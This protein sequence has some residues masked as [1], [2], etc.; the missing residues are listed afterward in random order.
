MAS[1]G[2]LTLF[3]LLNFGSILVSHYSTIHQI[4]SG[5]TCSSVT[6]AWLAYEAALCYLIVGSI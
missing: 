3:T 2:H 4:P 6:Q 5:L 1:P